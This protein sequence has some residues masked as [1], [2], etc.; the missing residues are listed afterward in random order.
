MTQ[1]YHYDSSGYYI[2]ADEAEL[3]PID[4]LPIVPAYATL[5]GPPAAADNKI[6]KWDETKQQWSQVADYRDRRYWT[7]GAGLIVITEAG[8]KPP[9]RAA[10]IADGQVLIKDA[11]TWRLRTAA[12]D[13]ADTKA[14]K[15]AGLKNECDKKIGGGFESS[16][17]GAAHKYDSEQHNVDWIQAAV[18]SGNK[19][20]IT[21]D[22]LKGAAASKKPRDHTP[23]QCQQVLTDGM[24]VLLEHKTRFRDLRDTV[25]KAAN[26]A[27]VEAVVWYPHHPTP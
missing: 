2:D 11:D 17:L 16:A 12:D 9:A 4:N 20:K 14:A 24:A 25:N 19:T 22:D 18:A 15:I 27:A 6:A 8:V 3:D 26:A 23:A 10:E 5:T 13:L 7:A 1:I 21:C